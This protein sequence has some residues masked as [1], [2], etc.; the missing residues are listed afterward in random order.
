MRDRL[1]YYLKKHQ[2]FCRFVIVGFINTFNY[3]LLYVILMNLDN[4]YIVSHTIAFVLSMIGS[5]YLNCY[6]TYQTRPT[7][8]KFFQFPMTYVVNYSVTTLSLYFLIGIFNI[9]EFI[10][11]LIAA[12]IPIPFTFMVS[13]WILTK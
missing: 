7:F 2:S 12:I 1:I 4:I 5:F 9:D 8:K 13:K 6:F 3:Y 10:A 11:P